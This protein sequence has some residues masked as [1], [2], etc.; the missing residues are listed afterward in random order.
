M[1]TNAFRDSLGGKQDGITLLDYNHAARLYTNQNFKFAPKTKFLYHCWFGIDP[2][3]KDINPGLIEKY[4][5]EIGLLVKQADLPRFTAN[6]ETKKKYNR[7][8]HIQTSIQYQPITLTFHDDNHGVTTALLEA[9][10]RWYYADGWHAS[11]PGAFNKAGD[12][13]NTYK[14]RERNQFRFGLDNNLSVPF[15]K[16]IQLSQIARTQYTTYTLVNPIITNWEHDSVDNSDGSG[17]MQNT[18]TV[19]YEAVHYSRGTVQVGPDGDPIAFGFAHYDS[20]PSPLANINTTTQL[21]PND[22]SVRTPPASFETNIGNRTEGTNTFPTSV[23]NPLLSSISTVT[24]TDDIGGISDIIIPKTQ[25]ADGAQNI[26]SSSPTTITT[27]STAA[28]NV[29]VTAQSLQN[30]P[31]K[32]DSLAI[33]QFKGTFLSTGGNGIND[34]I[35]AWNALPETEKEAY[36]KEVLEGTRQ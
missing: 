36:R 34:L 35:S 11:Q 18:I 6:V 9:Y 5:T 27:N 20:F 22:V 4:N 17:M 24:N 15:F 31:A 25:G 26:V 33:Q 23:S 3:V 1:S 30:N 12:G 13:D 28:R 10:Y 16:R 21:D 2:G 14:S 29:N 32:L 7:T 19:Q 8:K